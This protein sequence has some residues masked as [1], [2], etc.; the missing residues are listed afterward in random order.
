V[1]V[2]DK[3]E[4][5]PSRHPRVSVTRTPLPSACL[6]RQT[7]LERERFP[8]ALTDIES[9]EQTT[10]QRDADFGG[11]VDLDVM[12]LYREAKLVAIDK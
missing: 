4:V 10:S 9:H 1:V 7:A 8:F 5:R 2:H 12:R 3:V 6:Y 11:V